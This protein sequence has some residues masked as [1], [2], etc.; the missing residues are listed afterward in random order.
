MASAAASS[1]PHFPTTRASVPASI[2]DSAR[3]AALVARMHFLSAWRAQLR[4][5]V[6]TDPW[7][8]GA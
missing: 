3:A 8:E 5:L 4:R 1:A 7:P 2:R 6:P